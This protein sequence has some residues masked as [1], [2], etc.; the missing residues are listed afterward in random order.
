MGSFD[1]R[2]I[3]FS[4]VLTNLV[5][6]LVVI[7]LWKQYHKRYKGI[8]YLSFAF[9]FQTFTF[10]LIFFRGTI[11]LWASIDFANAISVIGILLGYMGLESYTG[12]KTSQLPNLILLIVFALVYTW[13]TY[14]RS[15]LT[16][17]YILILA[18]SLILFGQCTWLLLYRVPRKMKMFTKSTGL[19]FLAFCLVF[20]AKIVEFI[21]AGKKPV[22][23]FQS[24]I[25]EGI[26]LI[27]Y[28]MLL[29][30]LTYSFALM[31][32]KH[33]LSDIEFEEEKFSTAF[34]TST[35]AIVITRYP[36]RTDS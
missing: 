33:L 16:I 13:I 5:S 9:A 25:F 10:I 36:Q 27:L 6:T 21:I 7:F 18:V 11:P 26:T 22:D 15:E 32:G 35:N 4:F 12:K 31:F 23:Y 30:V 34:H 28:Q 8:A 2:T 14:V 24:G 19:V 20:I 17:R 3:I 1:I 29:V